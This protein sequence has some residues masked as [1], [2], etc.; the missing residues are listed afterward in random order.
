M[1]SLKVNVIGRAR[2]NIQEEVI[3]I[4]DSFGQQLLVCAVPYLRDKDLCISRQG[5]TS[6]ERESRI[7]KAIRDHYRQVLD[8]A[9]KRKKHQKV[10]IVAMGHLYVSGSITKERL[11]GQ[12][13][14]LYVGSLGQ[15]PIDIFP[16]DFHY[17]ALGHIHLAQKVGEDDR[18][19]YSGSPLPLNFS[20]VNNQRRVV[21]VE[22]SEKGERKIE[23]IDVPLFQE[24]VQIKGNWEHIEQQII[25]LK[26]KKSQAWVEVV[27]ESSVVMGD[28][29]AR[30][31]KLIES[32][33]LEVLRI[34]NT[35]V[36]KEAL[37]HRTTPKDLQ[38]LTPMDVFE[39][40][41]QDRQVD[42]DQRPLLREYY[43]KALRELQSSE[44]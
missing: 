28:L 15:V 26:Q 16:K 42:N 17:V 4:N 14:P 8:D 11:L 7:L 34:K 36:I 41:L 25:R 19:Q 31:L 44:D 2:Q 43:L 5:E 20:E 35:Q 33:S 22:F 13:D 9:I 21:L 30:V 1:Q 10:P 40:C 32:S 29:R 24:L 3:E 23:Y 6:Q 27:Y 18:I 37:S 39:F 12:A 38:Q